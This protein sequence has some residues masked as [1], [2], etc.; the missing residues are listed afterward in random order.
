VGR[1]GLCG[2][3]VFSEPRNTILGSSVMP[4]RDSRVFPLIVVSADMKSAGAL[5]LV[6]FTEG[7]DSHIALDV[8]A[9]IYRVME[10]CRRNRGTG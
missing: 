3:A 7:I 10:N 1:G 4:E 8:A 9:E 6:E 5:V 2:G